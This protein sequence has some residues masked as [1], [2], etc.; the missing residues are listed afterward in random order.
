MRAA[1]G[2][3]WRAVVWALI[4]V[5]AA[6]LAVAV[7]IP[8]V[9]GATPYTILTGSMRPGMPPG[10][11]VVVRPADAPDIAVGDVVTYQLRSGEPEVVTHRV[12]A[13]GLDGHGRSVFRTQGD[14]N[15][16][17]DEAWV[18]PVQVKGTRWYSVPYVGYVSEVL[19]GEQRQTA[20]YV[21]AGGLVVYALAM[22]AGTLRERRPRSRRPVEAGPP[23]G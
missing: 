20:V 22:F 12:V 13:Q 19:T 5:I 16:T 1:L 23:R 7:L 18:R 11:L 4:L 15:P 9:T 17:P 2:W 8:R 6:V 21:V 10:T 14:A 3:A